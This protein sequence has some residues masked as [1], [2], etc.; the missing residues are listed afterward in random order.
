MKL[1]VFHSK[2]ARADAC[3]MAENQEEA[4]EAVKNFLAGPDF[5][6]QHEE[7][8]EVPDIYEVGEVLW[9]ED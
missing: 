3:V 7:V 2:K 6:W 1:F 5:A 8:N 9:E 4:L